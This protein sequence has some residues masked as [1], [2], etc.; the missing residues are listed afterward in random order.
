[1]YYMSACKSVNGQL[2]GCA[3]KFGYDTEG[4]R[5]CPKSGWRI[6]WTMDANVE[7]IGPMQNVDV[8]KMN[9]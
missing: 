4:E 5:P 7:R 9:F 2:R 1:M 8:L 6:G 3:S